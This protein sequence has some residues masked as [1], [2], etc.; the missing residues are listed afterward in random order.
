M[1]NLLNH[2]YF[3]YLLVKEDITTRVNPVFKINVFRKPFLWNTKK[4]KE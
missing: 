2:Q 3:F 1:T 4:C